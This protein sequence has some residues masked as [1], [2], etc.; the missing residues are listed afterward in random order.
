LERSVTTTHAER[1]IEALGKT[2]ERELR[3]KY[4]LVHVCQ[5]GS[6]SADLVAALVKGDNEWE[7]KGGEALT[8]WESEAQRASACDAVDE[9]AKDI[10]R[11]WEQEDGVDYDELLDGEWLVS[12]ARMGLIDAVRERDGSEW[13]SE[14]VNRHG[15]VLLRVAI[16]K[17][18]EDAGLSYTA[19]EP[20]QFLDLLG[21]E[22]TDHNIRLAGELIDNALPEFSVAI[23][24]ALIGVDLE[25]VV[26]LPSS[27]AVGL[28]NPHVWLGNPFAGSGWCSEQAFT[29]TLTVD[30]GDL[31][32]DKDAFGYSWNEVVGGTSPNYYAG[33]LMAPANAQ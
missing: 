16:K 17:M 32:T 22:H 28:R 19:L 15:A 3:D 23:G 2:A 24:Q 8:E 12:D 7:T 31:K 27:G 4:D 11:R 21:F 13:F 9:L 25:T 5:G 33:E 30:R 26:H 18:D 14:L 20:E 1:T 29:G 6:L 10:V